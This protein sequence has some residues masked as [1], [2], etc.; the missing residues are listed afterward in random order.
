MN[1]LY[2]VIFLSLICILLTDSMKAQG[3]QQSTDK[4]VAIVNDR[5]VLKSDVDAE[6]LNYMRQSEIDGQEVNFSEE[7]WYS[8]LQ[9]MVDNYVLLE[10]AKL[11]SIEVSDDMV[12]RNMDQR[13]N[14]LIRQAGSERAL[15][16]AFGQSLIQIRAEFREQ[17]REQMIAQSVQQRKMSTISITRP[18]VEEFFNQ[19]PD[20]S[21]PTIPEQISLSQIVIIPQPL[22]DAKNEAYDR[23]Q[24]LRDSVTTYEKDF[25]EMARLY[26]EDVSAPNGGLI[27]MMPLDGLVSSYSAAAAALQPGGISQV[28][29]TRFGFHVIRLNRRSGDN[30]ETNHI[31]IKIDEDLV[32]EQAAIDKLNAIRDS[33]LTHDKNFADM[34]RLYSEDE[35]TNVFGGRIV[36]PQ[37]GRR[38]LQIEQLEPALYRIAL[39]LDEVG[40]ISE[41]RTYNPPSP[42]V[43]RAFRIVRL[44][45]HIPEHLAN[46]SQDYDQ[47][48]DFALQQKTTRI[49]GQWINDLR[50]EVYVEFKIP[51]PDSSGRIDEQEPVTL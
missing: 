43:N 46:L 21:M 2:R 13:I 45:R 29:E 47:I 33:V 8:A 10:K 9:S 19:I 22:E 28:V 12:T 50:D 14:Q 38:L 18:E 1:I 7:I 34:A 5:I 36:N 32:D 41:P 37:T 26:S 23:A 39:L 17:F 44:D 49:M 4:I 3:Q 27:P 42:T 48:R 35:N 15:E 31:L 30:I 6:I 20:E 51:I 24:A 40:Q 25:E 16:E 11:D